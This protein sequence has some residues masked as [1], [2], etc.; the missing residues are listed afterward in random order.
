[1]CCEPQP[2]SRTAGVFT[3]PRQPLENIDA[4]FRRSSP[5]CVGVRLQRLQITP[6]P[7]DLSRCPAMATPPSWAG[8]STTC[9]L[10]QRGSTSAAMVSGPS[11]ATSWSPTMR[12]EAPIKVTPSR[13]WRCSAPRLLSGPSP[14]LRFGCAGGSRSIAGTHRQDTSLPRH[15]DQPTISPDTGI[16]APA[17]AGSTDAEAGR[18][19]QRVSRRADVNLP[20]RG[21]GLQRLPRSPLAPAPARSSKALAEAPRPQ[22]RSAHEQLRTTAWQSLG[23]KRRL[24]FRPRRQCRTRC[25]CNSSF[26]SARFGSH[27]P[28]VPS[29]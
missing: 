16:A 7:P 8:Q 22:R 1:L 11:R 6:P 28:A 2:P 9:P 18:A 21:P 3:A 27:A 24:Y 20:R 14:A 13:S 4:D 10:G 23:K 15:A 25:G 5:D 26:A 29:P 12:L 19:V 17:G